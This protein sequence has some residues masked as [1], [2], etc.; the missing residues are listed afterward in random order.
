MSIHS[1]WIPDYIVA[2]SPRGLRLLMYKTNAIGGTQ[3]KYFDI[4][5]YQEN[6]KIRWIAWYYKPLRNIGDLDAN[7]E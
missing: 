6:G 1:D 2:Q 4:S 5:S 3:Y 7:A